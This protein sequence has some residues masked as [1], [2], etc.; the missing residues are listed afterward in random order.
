MVLCGNF[1]ES[2]AAIRQK[3][4]AHISMSDMGALC[5]HLCEVDVS[6]QSGIQV[7]GRSSVILTNSR[8]LIFVTCFL[9]RQ[10]VG[11]GVTVAAKEGGEGFVAVESVSGGGSNPSNVGMWSVAVSAIPNG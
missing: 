4:F 6:S 1:S 5:R 7:S 8:F 11:D 10:E 3:H 2:T 9:G